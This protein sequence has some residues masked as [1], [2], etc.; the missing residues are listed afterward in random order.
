MTINT[1]FSIF[2]FLILMNI[3]AISFSKIHKIYLKIKYNKDLPE[4]FKSKFELNNEAFFA[5]I[6]LKEKVVIADL[7]DKWHHILN[8]EN[9]EKDYKESNSYFYHFINKEFSWCFS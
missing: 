3:L 5:N 4:S 2:L 9:V 7:E 8:H 1:F 6:V